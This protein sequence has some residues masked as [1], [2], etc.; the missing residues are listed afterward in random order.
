MLTVMPLSSERIRLDNLTSSDLRRHAHLNLHLNLHPN[1]H[2][3]SHV[4][5]RM[6]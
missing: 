4:F 2:L 1:L 5:V 6:T 3:S